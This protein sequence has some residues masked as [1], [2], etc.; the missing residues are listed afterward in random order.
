[1]ELQLRQPRNME[2]YLLFRE[3]T[4]RNNPPTN[5]YS[6]LQTY[7]SNLSS[8]TQL[9]LRIHKTDMNPAPFVHRQIGNDGREQYMLINY[10]NYSLNDSLDYLLYNNG[11]CF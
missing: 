10:I 2:E 6:E 9:L 11:S 5:N 3:Q 1:M 4:Q 8:K 7:L